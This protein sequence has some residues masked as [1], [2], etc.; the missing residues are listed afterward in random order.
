MDL[1]DKTSLSSQHLLHQAPSVYVFFWLRLKSHKTKKGFEKNIY[2]ETQNKFQMKNKFQKKE[3]EQI[4]MG[5][6]TCHADFSEVVLD[7]ALVKKLLSVVLKQPDTTSC[8]REHQCHQFNPCLISQ[9][10]AHSQNVVSV[11]RCQFNQEY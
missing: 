2:K 4:E 10:S 11:G 8:F 1:S 3:I 5:V 9:A 7:L 6:W